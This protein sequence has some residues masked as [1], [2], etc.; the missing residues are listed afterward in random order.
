MNQ[1]CLQIQGIRAYGYTGFLAEEQTLGQWFEVDLRVWLNLSVAG[2]SDRLTDTYDYSNSVKLI[3]SLIQTSK[4]ALI[5]RLAEAIAQTILA[6]DQVTQV[7][8]RLIKVA[9]PIPNFDGRI[10]VDIT[11]FR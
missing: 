2:K 6:S 9:P 8:V 3:Q 4:F 7:R 10:V 11:R 5:E 1:D